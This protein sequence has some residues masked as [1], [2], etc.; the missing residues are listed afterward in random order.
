MVTGE[1]SE[2]SR[3]RVV[4][5]DSLHEQPQVLLARLR[6][7]HAHQRPAAFQPL[8]LQLELDLAAAVGGDRRFLGDPGALVPQVDMAAAILARR[9]VAFEFRVFDGMILGRH[10]QAL[11]RGICLRLLR[12]RPALQHAVHLEAEIVMQR[13]RGVL[14]HDEAKLVPRS[15]DRTARLRRAIE[16]ALG[17][18]ALKAGHAPIRLSGARPIPAPGTTTAAPATGWRPRARCRLRLPSGAARPSPRP[19]RPKC[20]RRDGNSRR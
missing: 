17:V 7:A 2:V 9:N 1:P 8:A 20:W 16:M 12:Y 5:I 3:A 10:G 15:R 14:L 4:G 13:G 6:V 11:Y 18:I 19:S